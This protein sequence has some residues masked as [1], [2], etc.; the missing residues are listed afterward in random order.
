MP[1]KIAL[2][3][4]VDMFGLGMK[5]P[6]PFPRCTPKHFGECLAMQLG[7]TI[8]MFS[9]KCTVENSHDHFPPD[10]KYLLP[11]EEY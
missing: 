2:V 4:E 5:R 10:Q 11:F 7:L 1:G 6:K 8:V 9:N 3:Y